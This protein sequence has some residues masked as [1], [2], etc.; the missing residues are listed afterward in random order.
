MLRRHP[1]AAIALLSTA[2]ATQWRPCAQPRFDAFA[3]LTVGPWVASSSDDAAAATLYEVEEVMRSCGGAV[4]GIRELPLSLIF[5]AEECPEE[6]R[7]Y[8]NRADGGFVYADDGTYSAGPEKWAWNDASDDDSGAKL[9]MASLAFTGKQRV[10]LAATLSEAS[11]A[12]KS[13]HKAHTPNMSPKVIELSRPIS[14]SSS[15]KDSSIAV[16]LESSQLPYVNWKTIQRVRMP[17]SSQAWSL[18]RAKWEKQVAESECNDKAVDD[19]ASVGPLMGWAY[20][21]KIPEGQENAL[22]GDAV[23]AAVA[24]AIHMLAACPASGVARSA[25]RCYGADGALKAVA[26]LDGD[27]VTAED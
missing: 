9:L 26:F 15:D 13:T 2:T 12:V 6:E 16:D 20:V 27:V 21:E 19:T 10:W 17:N 4:Q 25:V 7:T 5:D 23:S 11:E 22:F 14:T 8:H 3:E 18:A 1:L 24:V